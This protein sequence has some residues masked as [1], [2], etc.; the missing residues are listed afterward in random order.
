ML[1]GHQRKHHREEYNH[2]LDAEV[3]EQKKLKV[4]VDQLKSSG[5]VTYFSTFQKA[6]I[7]WMVQTYQPFTSCENLAFRT[8]CQSLNIQA[9]ILGQKKVRCLLT[10]EVLELRAD[11]TTALKRMYCSATMNA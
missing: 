8:L 4:D 9:P 3:Q 10:K 5:Y 1:L 2:V 6:Y 11:V 7:N